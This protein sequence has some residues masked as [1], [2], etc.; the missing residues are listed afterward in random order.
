MNSG[1]CCQRS[2]LVNGLIGTILIMTTT[3]QFTQ[4][5]YNLCPA[6]Y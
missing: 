5:A 6:K 3:P 1:S 2:P 4:T